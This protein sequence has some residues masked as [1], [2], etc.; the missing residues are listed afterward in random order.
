MIRCLAIFLLSL[1]ELLPTEPVSVFPDSLIDVIPDDADTAHGFL[2]GRLY[3]MKRLKVGIPVEVSPEKVRHCLSA[4]E[5]SGSTSALRRFYRHPEVQYI[6]ALATQ[7]KRSDT[8]W[9]MYV[10]QGVVQAP[11]HGRFRFVG[12]GNDCLI[13]R[14]NHQTVLNSRAGKPAYSAEMEVEE[15]KLYPIEL[16]STNALSGT[17]G[18]IL[19]TESF[20]ERGEPEGKLRLFRTGM[21][22]PQPGIMHYWQQRMSQTVCPPDDTPIWCVHCPQQESL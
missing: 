1:C 21:N 11:M 14:F 2:S 6:S 20:T 13:V 19:F 15:G 8:E 22:G 18:C 12:I 16:L 5:Q 3:D 10:Y 4:F 17:D 9:R 7:P